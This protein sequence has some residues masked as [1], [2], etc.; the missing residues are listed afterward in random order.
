[1]R[2]GE[3]GRGVKYKAGMRSGEGA[4]GEVKYKI[5]IEVS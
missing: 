1:M 5:R 2:S 4:G 3:G